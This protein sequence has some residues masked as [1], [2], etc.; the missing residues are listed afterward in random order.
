VLLAIDVGNTQTVL[1]VFEGDDLAWKWRM[2]TQHERT[3]DELALVF[4]GFLEQAGLSFTRQITGV[5]LASVVPD[6]TQALREMVRNYFHFQPVVV[7]PGIK[8]GISV[9][10]D[11]RGGRSGPNRQR[12]GGLRQVRRAVC[13]DRLRDGDHLRRRVRAR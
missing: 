8:T 1:G 7:E 10:T 3:A 4:G 11:N 9:Q 12:A 5:A 2:A 6:Q 13:G